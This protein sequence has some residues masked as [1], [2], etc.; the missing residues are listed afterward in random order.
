MNYV[1]KA[2]L[3]LACGGLAFALYLSVS[4]EPYATAEIED[5]RNRMIYENILK[6][7]GVA[8]RKISNTRFEFKNSDAKRV[9]EIADAYEERK[10][11][12]A[13]EARPVCS[14]AESR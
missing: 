10:R 4:F 9:N 2:A 6:E 12:T 14:I 7:K 1:I 8:I 3:F 5:C 11:L 13:P